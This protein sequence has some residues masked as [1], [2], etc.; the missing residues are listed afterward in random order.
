M[1]RLPLAST[2]TPVRKGITTPPKMATLISPDPCA[3]LGPSFSQASE[4]MV[5]NMIEF[6]RPIASDHNPR[7]LNLHQHRASVRRS[8]SKRPFA[9]ARFSTRSYAECIYLK[10]DR[11]AYVNKPLTDAVFVSSC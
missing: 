9:I 4:K 1:L 10:F 11:P 3:A 7:R 8:P 2:I 6:I 5:G